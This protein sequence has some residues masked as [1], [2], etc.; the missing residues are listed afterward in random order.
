MLVPAA[1]PRCLLVE[2]ELLIAMALE[3]SLEEA[4]FQ[5]AGP[6]ARNAAALAWLDAHTPD[7]ALIDVLLQDG[8]CLPL[9]R[10]LRVRNIPFAIYS[11]LKPGNRD[12]D[13]AAVPWLEK[14]VARDHLTKVLRD[15]APTPLPPLPAAPARAKV[16]APAG[17]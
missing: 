3:A 13:L 8:P 4:G 5:V 2:D 10:A 11:G 12:G 7:V 9:V 1:P 14:P 16:L 6:F 15:L 17:G